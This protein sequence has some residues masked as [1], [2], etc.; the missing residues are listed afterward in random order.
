MKKNIHK[1]GFALLSLTIYAA[2]LTLIVASVARLS[3]LVLPTAYKLMQWSAYTSFYTAHDFVAREIACTPRDGTLLLKLD[4]DGLLWRCGDR[5]K[6]IM[7][8]Q[9]NLVYKEGDYRDGT[10]RNSATTLLVRDCL[11]T[12]TQQGHGIRC[13]A[14]LTDHPEHVWECR[15]VRY[16]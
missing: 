1:A 15:Q 6:G 7:A 13:R 2:I 14:Q 11:F 10:V 9:G 8:K 4:D 5:V 3:C 16:V 12:V